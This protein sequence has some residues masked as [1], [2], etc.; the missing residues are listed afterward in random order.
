MELAHAV[1]IS[2]R[3][4]MD[5]LTQLGVV[6]DQLNSAWWSVPVRT[7]MVGSERLLGRA[8]GLCGAMGPCEIK[9][10]PG[11]GQGLRELVFDGET[12]REQLEPLRTG[13]G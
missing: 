6:G 9:A 7:S 13:W 10:N 11:H 3:E 1:L 8:G 4:L 2:S 12:A 5:Y